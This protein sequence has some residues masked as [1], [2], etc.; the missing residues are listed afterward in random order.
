MR[1]GTAGPIGWWAP[2]PRG[3][4]PL[5]GLVVHRSLRRACRRHR[6]SI[7][8]AFEDVVR[9]CA[10]PKRPHG[11]ID[12][13]FVAA[14]ARL[15]ELGWAHSV[16]VWHDTPDGSEL[17]GGLYGVAIGALFA[18]ESM[19]HRARDGS[20]V[21]LV[22]AVD[23]LRN[24]GGALF[25]VQWCTEHLASLGAIAIPRDEYLQRVADAITRP[26]LT[27]QEGD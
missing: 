22:A 8:T 14:Y 5:D 20:K 27:L 7:D 13:S 1:L 15:H 3:V 17:V 19:F 23:R 18:G 16:E 26:Q 6:V 11:W 2:D 9:G 10:D 12:E 25:D 21:A 4:L 24:G